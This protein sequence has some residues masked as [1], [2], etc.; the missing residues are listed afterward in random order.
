MSTCDL[1]GRLPCR[2]VGLMPCMAACTSRENLSFFLFLSFFTSDGT[3]KELG[4]ETATTMAGIRQDLH[5]QH[6]N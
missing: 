4:E 3:Q 6:D 2:A 1:I 5:E